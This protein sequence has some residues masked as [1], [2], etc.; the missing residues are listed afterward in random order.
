ME[1]IFVNGMNERSS[2]TTTENGANAFNTT[3]N[4]LVDLFGC[5]GSI[6]DRQP[7]E[8]TKMFDKAFEEDALLAT[9]MM[10]YARNVR[11]GLG[12]R[13][14]FRV[15]LKYLAEN[16]PSI[17]I[18]NFQLIPE[19]G[20]WD[21]LYAL[22]GT[23]LES[24]VWDTFVIQLSQDVK[25]Y[26]ANQPISLLAKWLK[27][28]NTSSKE[29]R[30][31]GRLTAKNLEITE[32]E[33]RIT[34]SV[35][36]DYINLVETKMSNNEWNEILFE[37]VPS[38][39][40]TNNRKAFQK[41]TPEL[42]SEYMGKVATGEKKINAA[43]LYPYDIIEA[44]GGIYSTGSVYGREAFLNVREDAV[45]EAQWKALPNYIKEGSNILVMAD[46]S[47]SM[48]GRPMATSV[49]LAIYF[50]ERNFGAFKNY[51]MTFSSKPSFVH[52]EGTTLSEKINKV[53]AIIDSTNLEAAFEEVLNLAIST[54]CP[55]EDLP[56]ALVVISDGEIDYFQYHDISWTFLDNMD[57]KFKEKGYILPK[58]VMWNVASRGNRFIEK[59]NSDK[60]IQYISGSSP[61]C[62]KDLIN[63]LGK[64]AYELMVETLN[65]PIYDDITV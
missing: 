33:Y 28:T 60:R 47:G 62:F 24:Y 57:I 50:A 20:R 44:M 34:L 9:K 15:L 52:L 40:M 53:P 27:S 61:S 23:Q 13:Q 5:I 7:E 29:S 59:A 54:N 63:N 58:V 19:F 30:R 41:H 18:Q 46:T 38:K 6:R 65:N 35:L 48:K 64:S 43:T 14:T 10:F 25:D 3:G 26:Q 21:D 11:G 17:L 8:V 32:K 22:V 51:F 31:L 42:F 1:N 4:S 36:R 2:R 49:G 39:C 45:A 55:Q 56:K 37:R 12:E 16:Y